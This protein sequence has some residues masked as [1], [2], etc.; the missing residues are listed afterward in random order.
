MEAPKI[1]ALRLEG[2]EP[3]ICINQGCLSRCTTLTSSLKLCSDWVV[4]KLGDVLWVTASS[5]THE[6]VGKCLPALGDTV[7][8]SPPFSCIPQPRYQDSGVFWSQTGDTGGACAGCDKVVPALI[9]AVTAACAESEHSQ[10]ELSCASWCAQC[11]CSHCRFTAQP[12]RS[13]NFISLHSKLFLQSFASF[14]DWLVFVA[15]FF[16]LSHLDLI[17]LQEMRA[18]KRK[19]FAMSTRVF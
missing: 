18:N 11:R 12:L 19:P 6:F 1:N 5:C 13:A 3:D 16:P 2:E 14:C 9:P 15:F 10:Q 17:I 8:R 4:L 7:T